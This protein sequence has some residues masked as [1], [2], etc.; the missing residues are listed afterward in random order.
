MVQ[1]KSISIE[2]QHAQSNNTKTDYA[3]AS[4]GKDSDR[5]ERRSIDFETT[6]IMANNHRGHQ[7]TFQDLAN[8]YHHQIQQ[9]R[10][11]TIV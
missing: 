7:Q 10:H 9:A 3:R 5:E 2:R 4:E 6:N 11:Q 8:T 1:T